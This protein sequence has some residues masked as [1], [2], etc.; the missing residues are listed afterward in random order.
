MSTPRET[1]TASTGTAWDTGGIAL[2]VAVLICC[3]VSAFPPAGGV[4]SCE[5]GLCRILSNK[6]I[7]FS[8][9]CTASGVNVTSNG[10]FPDLT[11]LSAAYVVSPAD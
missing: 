2:D 6:P 3:G 1:G 5:A 10:S 7:T 8:T 11:A 9:R 4:T